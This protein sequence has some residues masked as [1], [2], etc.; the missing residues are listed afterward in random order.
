MIGWLEQHII[1][2]LSAGLLGLILW[3]IR[4]FISTQDSHGKEIAA[5][6][7]DRVTRDDFDELRSSLTA[8]ATQNHEV[9]TDQLNSMTGRLDRVLEHMAGV[10]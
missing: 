6:K 8:T 10:K 3:N 5:L 9:V 4:R 1:E 2:L 7:E